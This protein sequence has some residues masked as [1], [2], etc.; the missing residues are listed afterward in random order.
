[1]KAC[2]REAGLYDA[3]LM[4]SDPGKMQARCNQDN[5]DDNVIFAFISIFKYH[6]DPGCSKASVNRSRWS[7]KAGLLPPN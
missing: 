5:R 6:H 2:S 7:Q 1:M 3:W 4:G